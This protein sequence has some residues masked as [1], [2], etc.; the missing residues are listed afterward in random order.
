V[1]ECKPLTLGP[2]V[3]GPWHEFL[4]K[5]EA[6]KNSMYNK[7]RR[8]LGS[9]FTK[10]RSSVGDVAE[11]AVAAEAVA[12]VGTAAAAGTEAEVAAVTLAAAGLRLGEAG[13]G[14]SG[15]S[16]SGGGNRL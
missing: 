6:K 7:M 4:R 11:A 1:N 10:R 9:V 14:G 12:A 2:N 5:E 15:A 13:S 8:G 3:D 16:G